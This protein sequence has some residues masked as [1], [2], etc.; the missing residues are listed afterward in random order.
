MQLQNTTGYRGLNFKLQ[1]HVT[2]CLRTKRSET[3]YVLPGGFLE[4]VAYLEAKILFSKGIIP[5][6]WEPIKS[7]KTSM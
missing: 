7:T 1:K 5:F 4:F 6:V 2:R 3:I